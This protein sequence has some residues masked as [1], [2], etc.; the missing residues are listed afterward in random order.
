M[1]ISVFPAPAAGKTRKVEMLTSGSSWTVPADVNY[2]VATL[3]GGGGGAGN[4]IAG[5]ANIQGRPGAPGQRIITTL[6]TTPAASISYGIGAG[7]TQPGGT[8]GTTTFTGATSAVGGI[9]GANASQS[10]LGAG[11]SF[12]GFDNGGQAHGGSGSTGAAHNGSNGGAGQ[13]ELE[14]WV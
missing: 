5:G 13:I 2:V 10:A 3:Q 7:G 11:T 14:Y 4:R 12:A 9:G 6:S 1:G 8:G